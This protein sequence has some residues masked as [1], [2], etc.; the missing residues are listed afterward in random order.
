MTQSQFCESK[1][2]EVLV[3]DIWKNVAL[4]VNSVAIIKPA[5][6]VSLGLTSDNH[7]TVNY[8]LCAE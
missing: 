6:V 4:K 1:S 7:L 3:N 5:K 8:M 2:E